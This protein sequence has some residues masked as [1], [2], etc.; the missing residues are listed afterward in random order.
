MIW[1]PPAIRN[2]PNPL[3]VRARNE[4][5]DDTGKNKTNKTKKNPKEILG[6]YLSVWPSRHSD[7]HIWSVKLTWAYGVLFN[8]V[9]GV[10]IR[11]FFWF[12]SGFSFWLFFLTCSCCFFLYKNMKDI[13]FYFRFVFFCICIYSQDTRYI[14]IYRWLNLKSPFSA[15]SGAYIKNVTKLIST[16]N[17]KILYYDIFS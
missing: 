2:S 8:A 15:L 14:H 11:R 9:F 17:N 1:A 3:W 6:R 5:K 16:K 13:Y 4:R 7:C 10:R 12:P